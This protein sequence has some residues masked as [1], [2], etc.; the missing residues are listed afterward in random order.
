[1]QGLITSA[2]FITSCSFG[3]WMASFFSSRQY[4]GTPIITVQPSA[5]RNSINCRHSSSVYLRPSL[6]PMPHTVTTGLPWWCK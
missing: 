4:V 2:S 1:M 3:S 5:F 6:K